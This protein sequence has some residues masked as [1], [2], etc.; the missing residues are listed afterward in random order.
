MI[1]YYVDDSFVE[2]NDLFL[3]DY[4][5]NGEYEL[6][7]MIYDNAIKSRYWKQFNF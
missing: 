2:Y 3:S 7:T 5:L 6:G 4:D 1:F